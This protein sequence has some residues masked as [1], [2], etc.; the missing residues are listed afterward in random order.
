MH[1][2]PLAFKT[3]MRSL[4]FRS[5]L[6]ARTKK[7]MPTASDAQFATAAARAGQETSEASASKLQGAAAIGRRIT[8]KTVKCVV[9]QSTD[10]SVP[11]GWRETPLVDHELVSSSQYAHSISSVR[12]PDTGRLNCTG[13]GSSPAS[14]PPSKVDIEIVR[15]VPATT[16]VPSVKPLKVWNSLLASGK[17]ATETPTALL[18]PACRPSSTAPGIS[19]SLSAKLIRRELE[20]F[21]STALVSNTAPSRVWIRFSSSVATPS[22][23]V[24]FS[25]SP[26]AAVSTLVMS[27]SWLPVMSCAARV[28][29]SPASLPT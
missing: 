15:S 17:S 3:A 11:P 23:Y 29:L 24:A 28:A 25:A 2:L 13:A 12:F 21:G 9:A 16:L 10:C 1:A 20:L 22:R 27:C 7:P 6:R 26:A 5:T 8:V 4:L 19:T 18:V 14:A